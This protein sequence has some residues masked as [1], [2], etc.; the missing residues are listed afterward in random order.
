MVEYAAI[1]SIT[2]SFHERGGIYCRWSR[3]SD[4]LCGRCYRGGVTIWDV[5]VVWYKYWFSVGV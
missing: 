4:D 1:A 2:I 3:K 5:D